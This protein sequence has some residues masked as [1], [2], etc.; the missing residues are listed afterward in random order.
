M[1]THCNRC[2]KVAAELVPEMPPPSTIG[3]RGSLALDMES[4][5]GL[6]F[7]VCKDCLGTETP[8]RY[9]SRCGHETPMEE[10]KG[11]GFCSWCR[12]AEEIPFEEP[13][14]DEWWEEKTSR[15]ERPAQ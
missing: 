12:A 5:P 13:D 9:C 10:F 1:N 11:G 14:D 3:E 4:E 7:M 8:F 6:F 2:G 15:A